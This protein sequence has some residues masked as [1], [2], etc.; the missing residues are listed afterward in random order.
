V[1]SDKSA[2]EELVEKFGRMATPTLVI[3]ERFFLG[4]K[5]NREEVEKIVEELVRGGK[6]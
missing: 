4:F 1:S 6:V 3:G 5:Q 2:R